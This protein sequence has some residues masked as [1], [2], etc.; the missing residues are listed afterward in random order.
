M[1]WSSGTSAL[2]STHEVF[3]AWPG[4]RFKLN[5]CVLAVLLATLVSVSS[6]AQGVISIDRLN[7]SSAD[8]VLVGQSVRILLKFTNLGTQP[9]DFSNG[10][11]ISSP[12]GAIWSGAKIELLGAALFPEPLDSG[13]VCLV[14]EGRLADTLGL[15]VVSSNRDLH[16]LEAGF[17]DTLVAL[18]MYVPDSC[19]SGKH[20][21]ID[22]SFF[23]P[24]GTWKWVQRSECPIWRLAPEW[25]G[26]TPAQAYVP[27]YGYCF[28]VRAASCCVGTTGNVNGSGIVDLADLSAMVSYLTGGGYVLPCTQEANVNNTGIVDLAD[29]SALVSYLTGG[30][31]VLPSCL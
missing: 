20:I 11:R 26:L 16:I 29:L 14:G 13:Y 7:G 27:N 21:C 28:Y 18:S 8:T 17:D 10:W 31:Y 3:L 6:W 15:I 30:G 9:Y 12:D 23:S 22:S 19:P 4:N 1:Y 24:G 5:P 25:R 2:R